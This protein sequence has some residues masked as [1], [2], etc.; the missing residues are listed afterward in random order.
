MERVWSEAFP[1]G[2]PNMGHP[3]LTGQSPQVAAMIAALGPEAAIPMLAKSA[4]ERR[5]L[6]FKTVGDQAFLF[7][8]R[9]GATVPVPGVQP[10]PPEA[11][12]TNALKADAAYRSL[13]TALDDYQRLIERE[14]I[15][16]FPG[17][18]RDAV[19][20]ARTNIQLQLKELYNLGVLNGP[21]LQL[22][23]Q[24]LIDPSPSI[25]NMIAN[26]SGRVRASVQR[27]KQMLETVR[28]NALGAA[29]M[30]PQGGQQQ[31]VRTYN[32]ATGE[33]E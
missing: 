15:A 25:T 23:E 24:M 28:N 7:D 5:Q 10:K 4:M 17:Q 18:A 1:G 14:G 8:P 33:L 13:S 21:D 20:Q 2:Q 6:E 30:Q 12:R 9:T 22:M 27:L 26:P 11:I 16:A 31:R 29:G 32:P 19:T 3:L